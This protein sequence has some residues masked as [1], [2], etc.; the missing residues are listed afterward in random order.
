TVTRFQLLEKIAGAD[1]GAIF[2]V[3]EPGG[4]IGNKGAAIAGAPRF[5]P[6]SNYLLFLD[7]AP[8][9]RW[10]S[11]MLAYGLLEETRAGALKP[12]READGIEVRTK[13][14]VEP[15]GLYR[16]A[17][18]LAHLKEVARGAR[19]N[20]ERVVASESF[21]GGA[22][23]SVHEAL[24][25]D[26]AECAWL[27]AGDGLPIRWFGFE[28]SST[29]ISIAPSNPGQTGIA[30]GGVSAVQQGT[31]SWTNHPDSVIRL[32][33]GATQPVSI[34][35]SGNFDID[36]NAVVFNDPC[37]DIADLSGCV[38]TLA[39]GGTLFNNA[40][41]P[42]E[43]EPWHPAIGTYVVVNN[44]SQCVGETSFKEVVAHELG[45]TQ[46]FNHHNPPNS[47]DAL[48][49]AMLKA[50][51]LGPALRVT[52]KKCASYAYHTF[53]DVPY[54]DAFWRYIEA[55][56]NAGI[57]SGCR[58]GAYC[59]DNLVTRAEMAIFLVRG[60]HGSSFVP[61]PA[62]GTIFNDVPANHWA[63]AY[64]EQLYKDGITKGCSTGF[65]CP[66]DLVKRSEMAVFLTRNEHG[67]AFVPPPATGTIFA[68]VPASYWA[69]P[70]V[71]Q[72]YHD[73]VTSGCATN[74]TRYCPEDYVSRDQMAAFLARSLGL[75]LP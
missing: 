18:I 70:Y 67:S 57:T 36:D 42:F 32:S 73:G 3:R 17:E 59:P 63:G 33:A 75:P 47:A 61:P 19:W 4:R 11:K 20:R 13:A 52:D 30:D 10:Q 60:A 34:S 54:S 43:G 31:A 28:T 27:L 65:Y 58:S 40:T 9:G 62:T 45:H 66:G 50:D 6:E 29:P 8:G 51:G 55:I 15:V 26:P 46:G 38:G 71:E 7:P 5:A 68:D 49:S 22:L 21:Q 56:E 25:G 44:G 14:S 1:P 39:L 41:Q 69:A 74:P 53:T 24:H 2:E 35:C 37:N 16:K 64:I 12:L 23:T 48:M 72:I